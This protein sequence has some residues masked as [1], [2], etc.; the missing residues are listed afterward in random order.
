MKV[1]SQ[2]SDCPAS[3]NA[4]YFVAWK[5]FYYSGFAPSELAFSQYKESPGERVSE[6]TFYILRCVSEDIF[7]SQAET[8]FLFVMCHVSSWTA[9]PVGQCSRTPVR[10]DT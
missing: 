6:L 2:V 7:S 10:Y 8:K 5:K 3:D 1:S 4:S 9:K